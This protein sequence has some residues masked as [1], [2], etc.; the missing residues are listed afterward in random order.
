MSLG[1]MTF[2]PDQ[3]LQSLIPIFNMPQQS[4]KAKKEKHVWLHGIRTRQKTQTTPD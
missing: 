2:L 1:D 4:D 3:T